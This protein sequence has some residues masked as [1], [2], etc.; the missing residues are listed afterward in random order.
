MAR[1]LGKHIRP[2]SLP[3]AGPVLQNVFDTESSFMRP[4]TNAGWLTPSIRVRLILVSLKPI[5]GNT[6]FAPHDISGL[7]ELMGG[8]PKLTLKLDQSSPLKAK[9][10]PRAVRHYGIDR[11]VCAW[12]RTQPSRAYCTTSPD[13]LENAVSR[14]PDHGT[15]YTAGPEGLIEMKTAVDVGLVRMSAAGFYPVTPAHPFYT[16]GT[17]LFLNYF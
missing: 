3:R 10:R 17:T 6:R 9:P 15:F 1:T 14:A 11:P 13:N 4:R 16:I 12:Q 2:P 8:R 5:R 7:I